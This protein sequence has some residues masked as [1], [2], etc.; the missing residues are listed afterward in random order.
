MKL[1]VRTLCIIS[2]C[3]IALPLI[4][5]PVVFGSSSNVQINVNLSG[6][7]LSISPY[8]Y[9]VTTE[10]DITDTKVS[11]IIQSSVRYS[12]YN[13]EN[14]SSNAGTLFY[15]TSDLFLTEGISDLIKHQPGVVSTQLS[16][17]ATVNDIPYTVVTLPM[18]DYVAKD[19]K[20]PVLEEENAPSDRWVRL[21]VTKPTAFSDSPDTTDNA[22][23]TDE[24]VYY[25]V[26]KLGKSTS[27]TGI[28]AFSLDYCPE[29]WD[30]VFPLVRPTPLTYN[31]LISKST[32]LAKSIKE[33]DPNVEIIGPSLSGF[34][35]YENFDYISDWQTVRD[36]YNWFVDY[37]LSEM[38]KA[39]DDSGI[40][41]LDVMAVHYYTEALSQSGVSVLDSTDYSD[42]ECNTARM[43]AVRTLWDSSYIEN[44]TIGTTK[45]QYLPLLIALK[46][47][48]NTYYP[49]TKIALTEYNFGGGDHISGG[50]AQVDALGTFGA[51]GVYLANLSQ[52]NDN[53]SFQRLAL[54]LFT[55]YDGN[56]SGFGDVYIPSETSDIEIS[57]SYASVDSSNENVLKLIVT[58]KSGKSM[59]TQINL[60]NTDTVYTSAKAYGFNRK[61]DSIKRFSD[62]KSIKN[63]SFSY[64]LEPYSV[65]EL[66]VYADDSQ[67]TE[68]T[69]TT[70]T[71]VSEEP[72]I[73]TVTSSTTTT[74]S[75]VSE[76]S[77]VTSSV[78]ATDSISDSDISSDTSGDGSQR[79][80]YNSVPFVIL[81]L[82]LSGGSAGVLLY[83]RFFK[84]SS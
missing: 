2:V 3:L 80:S 30:N 57:T 15:H 61:S 79:N 29:N 51:Q 53:N 83:F 31:E 4:S 59:Q 10:T 56:G 20:G 24:Y 49:E 7:R 38:K 68:V 11:S 55:N 6:G 16:K 46:A 35:S 66:I 77:T 21:Y 39:E 60:N 40:R 73:T 41:L 33:I 43:Q 74:T 54:N 19:S 45:Q 23:Y 22:I 27:P 84:K 52:V 44:S 32:A 62:V 82:I 34:S 18:L 69:T 71:P 1:F 14:N 70:E 63:N 28:K 13:W 50:I 47:S 26:S 8:I 12:S 25:L 72:V 9:G 5:S 36:D 64:V 42:A 37:Y 78:T 76:T 81:A 65:I 48:I 58:N 67:V 75:S 17:F